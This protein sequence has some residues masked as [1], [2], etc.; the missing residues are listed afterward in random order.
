MRKRLIIWTAASF[1]YGVGFALVAIN[2]E[3]KAGLPPLVVYSFYGFGLAFFLFA[4]FTSLQ[5]LKEA[6][7]ID[8]EKPKPEI[9]KS[10][11]FPP[12][13]TKIKQPPI[14]SGYVWMPIDQ[15][16]IIALKEGLDNWIAWTKKPSPPCSCAQVIRDLQKDLAELVREMESDEPSPIHEEGIPLTQYAD[17]ILRL[18]SSAGKSGF[19]A[20]Q[21]LK[22]VGNRANNKIK[23]NKS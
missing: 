17:Y 23:A 22:A 13:A 6:L 7:K 5:T 3:T 14:E 11:V 16:P 4:T 8:I 15:L 10:R 12:P 9:D 19:T 2:M 21:I 1:S 18:I 20:E